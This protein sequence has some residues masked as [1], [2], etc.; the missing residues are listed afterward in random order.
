MALASHHHPLCPSAELQPFRAFLLC[1]LMQGTKA[2]R[3]ETRRGGRAAL[4]LARSRRQ[5]LFQHWTELCRAAGT[6]WESELPGLCQAPETLPEAH[7]V[8]PD[9]AEIQEFHHR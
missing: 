3:E 9:L 7:S 6:G 8:G 1:E 4:Q 5:R 2:V